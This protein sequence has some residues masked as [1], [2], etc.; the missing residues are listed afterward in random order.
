MSQVE[1]SRAASGGLLG[2]ED[3]DRFRVMPQ[4]HMTGIQSRRFRQTQEW[5]VQEARQ[6][7]Y[8]FRLEDGAPKAAIATG[9]ALKSRRAKLLLAQEKLRTSAAT[10]ANKDM[11]EVRQLGRLESSN[12]FTEGSRT[13]AR[14]PM[15]QHT[16]SE[17]ALLGDPADDPAQRRQVL[18]QTQYMH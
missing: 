15:S 10:F 9:R 11:G 16:A 3:I 7:S 6:A 8:R 5:R 12:A 18:K 2:N 1:V 17:A 13:H 14:L 4:L